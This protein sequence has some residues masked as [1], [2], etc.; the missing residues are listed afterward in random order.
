[1]SSAFILDANHTLGALELGCF[2]S[3]VLFGVLV[4]QGYVYFQSY[5][6]DRP[7]L[8]ILASSLFWLDMIDLMARTVHFFCT[9]RH[10][11]VRFLTNLE[12]I[13]FDGFLPGC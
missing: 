9:G 11:N 1:M 4:T 10:D 7:A 2:C 5:A 3:L 13:P 6:T 8:K 12:S